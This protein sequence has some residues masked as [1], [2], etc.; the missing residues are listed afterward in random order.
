M[1]ELEVSAAV[2]QYIAAEILEGDDEGLNG[3]TPL[4]Q[5][6][7]LNS[8]EM[9]RLLGFIDRQFQIRIAPTEIS[10]AR[11]R[12]IDEIAAFVVSHKQGE[13]EDGR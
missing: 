3:Q 2:R 6:G 7:I 4:L 5:W 13:R 9:T 11:F 12:N 10:P 1:D 8:M